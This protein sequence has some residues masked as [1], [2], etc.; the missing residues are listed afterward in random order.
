MNLLKVDEDLKL[1]HNAASRHAYSVID[2]VEA[3]LLI[4]SN[5]QAK[6]IGILSKLWREKLRELTLPDCSVIN[7]NQPLHSESSQ[8][9]VLSP[10]RLTEHVRPLQPIHGCI[11]RPAPFLNPPEYAS[12]LRKPAR[13]VKAEDDVVEKKKAKRNAKLDKVNEIVATMNI[14]SDLVL[15]MQLN[16]NLSALLTLQLNSTNSESAK[17]VAGRVISLMKGSAGKTKVKLRFRNGGEIE[18]FWPD[19]DNLQVPEATHQ[20]S[21]TSFAADSSIIA[22]GNVNKGNSAVDSIFAQLVQSDSSDDDSVHAGLLSSHNRGE[23]DAL[24]ILL[25]GFDD[26]DSGDNLLHAAFRDNHITQADIAI[27]NTSTATHTR[28]VNDAQLLNIATTT[29]SNSTNSALQTQSNMDSLAHSL[30]AGLPAQAHREV[31]MLATGEKVDAFALEE[32]EQKYAHYRPTFRIT[33]DQGTA[34]K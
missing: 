30:T 14:E 21:A 12:Q 29:T 27:A 6:Q 31:A 5:I 1:L 8:I 24:R 25:E 7:S 17:W 16:V 2:D 18:T 23:N 9:H 26:V 4:N 28:I 32:M 22:G 13:K 33:P 20:N 34:G 15:G 11:G 10:A 3:K 19:N